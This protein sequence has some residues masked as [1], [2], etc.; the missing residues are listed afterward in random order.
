MK[1][2]LLSGNASFKTSRYYLPLNS[3][4]YFMP[5]PMMNIAIIHCDAC[6]LLLNRSKYWRLAIKC[7]PII[8]EGINVCDNRAH[9]WACS[10]LCETHI[11]LREI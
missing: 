9:Y 11:I 10:K 7:W 5:Y 2:M 8:K 4:R 1:H 6:G 3:K